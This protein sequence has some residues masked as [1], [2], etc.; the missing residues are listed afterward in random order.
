MYGR[1]LPLAGLV[2]ALLIPGVAQA[3]NPG[4]ATTK[5]NQQLGIK[6]DTPANGASVPL[7]ALAVTGTVSLS[8]LGGGGG[9]APPAIVYI[10]DTSGSTSSPT[11]DCNGDGAVNATDDFN[12]DSSLGD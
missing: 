10:V 8:P 3:A 12:G 5:T 1:P 7:A 2:L 6:I 9:G 4:A 11:Q